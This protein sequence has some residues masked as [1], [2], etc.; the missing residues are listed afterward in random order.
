MKGIDG[1][2][3]RPPYWDTL[4]L[5]L[6][7]HIMD[8]DGIKVNEINSHRYVQPPKPVKDSN[9]ILFG[10][11][12]SLRYFR[13]YESQIVDLVGFDKFQ[14]DCIIFNIKIISHLR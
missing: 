11:F 10:Y 6:K 9:M 12:Q 5:K 4:F 14:E 13:D 8:V 3:G 7:P 2:S 1:K